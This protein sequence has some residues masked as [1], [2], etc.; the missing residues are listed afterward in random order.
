MF[1]IDSHQHFWK[2][3][4]VNYGWIDDQMAVIRRDFLPEDLEPILK[5]NGFDGCIT[6]Q[7]EQSEKENEFQLANAE[8]HSFIK[9]VVGW[10]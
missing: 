4:P 6:V 3:D 2:Y 1:R 10:V 9:G 8:R 7:S 5:A